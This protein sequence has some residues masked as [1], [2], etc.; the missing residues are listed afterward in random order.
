MRERERARE[1]KIKRERVRKSTQ[2]EQKDKDPLAEFL[3]SDG[4]FIKRRVGPVSQS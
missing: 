2:Q 4:N 1:N 3:L